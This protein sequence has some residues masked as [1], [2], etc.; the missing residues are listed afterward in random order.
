MF[1][2]I[3]CGIAT[4]LSLGFFDNIFQLSTFVGIFSQGF[5]SGIFG[6]A[7]FILT[8][9]IIKNREYQAV[10]YELSRKFWKS[11]FVGGEK[12]DL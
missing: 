12:T 1:A 3:L 8:L 11:S 4:Y 9:H 10:A 5:F 7:V 2:S 6:I